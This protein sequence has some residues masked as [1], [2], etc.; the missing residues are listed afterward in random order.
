MGCLR[1][2]V[3][4]TPHVD[5]SQLSVGLDGEGAN[6]GLDPLMSPL[7]ASEHLLRAL[8][9][10]HIGAVLLDPLLDDSVAFAKKLR[11]VGGAVQLHVFPDLCHGFLVLGAVHEPSAQASQVCISWIREVLE[12]EDIQSLLC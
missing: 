9:P 6:L 8:P 11:A 5:R 4:S 3:P 10:V 2:Y 12:A 1:A 7:W